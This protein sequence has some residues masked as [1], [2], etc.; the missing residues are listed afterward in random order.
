MGNN[1]GAI[2]EHMSSASCTRDLLG[3]IEDN[4]GGYIRAVS[5]DDE[6]YLP[7]LVTPHTGQ[8]NE[9]RRKKKEENK[10][11][12][13]ILKYINDGRIYYNIKWG[14]V[15]D[16]LIAKRHSSGRIW[17]VCITYVA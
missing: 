15:V 11:E 3:N 17:Q 2:V 16:W 1:S 14:G 9:E 4:R 8:D 10:R 6:L 5:D 13:G 12:G 7:L